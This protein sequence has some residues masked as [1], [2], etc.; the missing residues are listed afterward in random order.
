MSFFS[1]KQ[2]KDDRSVLVS[3]RIHKAVRSGAGHQLPRRLL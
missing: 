3:V 1:L 2:A